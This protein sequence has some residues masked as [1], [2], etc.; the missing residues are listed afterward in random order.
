MFFPFC[1]AAPGAAGPTGRACPGEHRPYSL[2]LAASGNILV[3]G[4]LWKLV[5]VL[6]PNVLR[7][8]TEKQDGK[9][10]ARSVTWK[11]S[12][13]HA[14]EKRGVAGLLLGRLQARML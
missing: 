3:M 6:G 9:G 4:G 11:P 14:G 2:P 1:G 10:D 7:L 12:S 5:E 13:Q 8:I